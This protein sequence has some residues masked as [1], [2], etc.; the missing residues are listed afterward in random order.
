[1]T[2]PDHARP[3]ALRVIVLGF[4]YAPETTGIAPYTTSFARH[5]AA[6][7]LEVV[8]VSGHPHYPEW[9]VHVGYEEVRAPEVDGGVQL[10]RVPHPVPRNPSGLSRIWMETV[11]AFRAGR[12]LVAHR[13]DV[14]VAVSPALLA[15]VP[16]VLLRGRLHHRAGAIVQDLYGAA[17]AETGL[18]GRLL[19]RAT[20]LLEA[21]LLRRLDGVVVIHD[22][23]RSSLVNNGVDPH[24]IE[25]IP[26]WAHVSV[27]EIADRAPLRRELGWAE[28][29]FIALHAGN[30]GAKQGLEG[31]VEVARLA[32]QRGSRV[33]VVL[34]G[35]GSRHGA[36]RESARGISRI[37]LLDPLPPGRFEAALTAADCLLLHERPGLVEMSV[38]SKLTTYFAA[39]R[40]VVAA[41]DH[42]SGAAAL[43][44]ASDAGLTVPSGDAAAMLTAIERLAV[45]AGLAEEHARNGRRFAAEHLTAA[46]S[47][48]RKEAWVRRL[49]DGTRSVRPAPGLP[50]RA[51][52]RLTR[53]REETGHPT[54]TSSSPTCGY[55]GV[56]GDS[57]LS[58]APPPT[59]AGPPSLSVVMPVRNAE[60]F[61]VE[62]L[63]S[64]LP[65][66]R[67]DDE[68]VVQDGRSTDQTVARI[69]QG[70]PGESRI[71]VESRSDG[72]QSEALNAALAR[73]SGD[74]V[75]WLNADDLIEEGAVKAIRE[76]L[77]LHGRPDLLIGAHAVVDQ[78][79]RTIARY[80]ARP[81]TRKQLFR[82]GCYVFSGSLIVR[83]DVLLRL[84]GFPTDSH[85]AMDLDLQ[86]RMAEDSSLRTAAVP[87]V[88]GKLRWHDAS[89]SGSQAYAFAREGWSVRLRHA[90]GL[91][92]RLWS[93]WGVGVQ[94]LAIATTPVR[95][96]KY[97]E[98]VRGLDR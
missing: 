9:K 77:H 54:L 35:T 70:F 32:E 2:T 98:Y 87:E 76:S 69:A 7:D 43:M 97:W 67:P 28:D 26:N 47:L 15:L 91:S 82:E 50:G 30:M 8:V 25:V 64:V 4:N 20:A 27:P 36:I 49:A 21:A 1:M 90:R 66:L 14:V 84:G 57:V 5:L 16:A 75:C 60:A 37:T 42:R 81:L 19:T 88:I 59:P 23:F 44:A 31:L 29:E 12:Q 34:L 22:V 40:P 24:R 45:D 13:P 55:L 53:R 79:G 3:R 83:R 94:V 61:I 86:L 93:I 48:D 74:Y 11:Y 10:V 38:P 62:A 65:Q 52:A 78:N 80:R 92:D 41:T 71:R 95:H 39:G 56:S 6:R 33:R 73:S 72:G 68:I 18:G 51:A 17:L 58:E 46:A 96:S 63:E 89:K 85:Y